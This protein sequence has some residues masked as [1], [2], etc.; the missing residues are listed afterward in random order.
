[1]E[2]IFGVIEGFQSALRDAQSFDMCMDFEVESRTGKKI[3]V[4]MPMQSYV[5]LVA[6]VRHLIFE[7]AQ[8]R[9]GLRGG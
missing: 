9:K 5:A 3:R 6:D 2:D 7:L 8:C 4:T 1:V